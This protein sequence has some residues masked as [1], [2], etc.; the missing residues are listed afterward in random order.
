M[1][2]NKQTNSQFAELTNKKTFFVDALHI[3]T[4]ALLIFVFQTLYRTEQRIGHDLASYVLPSFAMENSLGSPYNDYFIN[5]PPG[6]FV[7][8]Q[9]WAKVFGYKL[10]SWVIL[11]SILLLVISLTIYSIFN[12]LIPKFASAISAFLALFTL[13]FSGTLSM[14]LPLEIIGVFIV[15]LATRTLIMNN[16]SFQSK[17]FFFA[18]LIFAASV[19]EQYSIVFILMFLSVLISQVRERKLIRATQACILGVLL[20]S[21]VLFLHFLMNSNFVGFVSVFKDQFNSEKQPFSNYFGW[22]FDAIYFH[23][24]KSFSSLIFKPQLHTCVIFIAFSCLL[25]SMLSYL[26][27]SPSKAHMF[28]P[29]IIGMTGF[30]LIASVSWQSSGFR[31][32]SHYAISSLVGIYLCTVSLTSFLIRFVRLRFDLQKQWVHIPIVLLLVLTPS[33]ETINLFRITLN[34][35]STSGLA[36]Q[37]SR[38][39]S[40]QPSLNE[41]KAAEIIRR[42]SKD[43]QCSVSVYGWA[44][45]SFYLYSKSKPCTK[46]FL[47]NLVASK[48]MASDYRSNIEQNPPRVINY[49]CLDYLSCSDLDI[50]EFEKFVFPYSKVIEDCYLFIPIEHSLPFDANSMLLFASR[51]N[52]KSDQ[53]DCIKAVTRSSN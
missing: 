35:I 48:Q 25:F 18:L 41:L 53:S 32:S 40:D 29:F 38:I 39:T 17:I 8:I 22:T 4:T 3:C 31:F 11:E 30:S 42:S 14:F 45:G 34:K 21:S 12:C 26:K 10:Q 20:T 50:S 37:F 7:F 6:T 24:I 27:N 49:G 9:L 15:L 5:R 23:S 1:M 47:P 52:K 51:Y 16:L 19:R 46:Y 28:E 44:S 2:T 36:T 43:F 33:V 13:L